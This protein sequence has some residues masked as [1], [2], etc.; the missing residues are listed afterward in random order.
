MDALLQDHWE[1]GSPG[2]YR[3]PMQERGPEGRGGDQNAKKSAKR[4]LGPAMPT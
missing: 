4:H 3:T 1:G 2:K